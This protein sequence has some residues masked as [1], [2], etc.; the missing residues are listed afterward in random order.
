MK[1]W[2]RINIPSSDFSFLLSSALKMPA[3]SLCLGTAQTFQ[4]KTQGRYVKPISLAKPL[5]LQGSVSVH[6]VCV[7]SV[8]QLC[9]TLCDS[10]DCSPPGFSVHGVFQAR[11]LEWVAISSS[12]GIF[13]IQ[14]L[15][16]CLLHWQVILYHGAT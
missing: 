16:M 10:A 2:L 6:Q 14:G 7:C 1:C 3:R 5:F 15:N 4:S 12:R 9:L 13:L 11:I 8:A